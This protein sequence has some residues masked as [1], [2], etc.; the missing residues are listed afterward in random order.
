MRL[1]RTSNRHMTIPTSNRPIAVSQRRRGSAMIVVVALLGVMSFLGV[2]FF[3]FVNAERNSAGY[4]A[5]VSKEVS[6]NS[7]P[8]IY[9]N[10]ALEQVLVGPTA[11]LTHSPLYGGKHSLVPNLIG[12][13]DG[14][15]R[16]RDNYPFSGQ[17]ITIIA[18]GIDDDGFPDLD[19]TASGGGTE[20]F[21]V[22]YDGDGIADDVNG[23]GFTNELDLILNYSLHVNDMQVPLGVTINDYEPDVGY[24]Y[25]DANNMFLG[26]FAEVDYTA[27]GTYDPVPVW[28]PSFHRPQY[29][30]RDG[31]TDIYT[32]TNYKSRILRPHALHL[33]DD[34]ANRRYLSGTA[35]TPDGTVLGEFPFN[36]NN[37]ANH[38][39]DQDADGQPLEMGIWSFFNGGALSTDISLL[40]ENDYEFDLDADGD[41]VREAIIMDLQFPLSEVQVGGDFEEFVPM[42]GITI[43][44]ADALLNLNAHGGMA[45]YVHYLR[46]QLD[47]GSANLELRDVPFN[48]TFVGVSN[49]GLSSNEVNLSR[50]LYADPATFG[51][52][53]GGAIE[54]H[55]GMFDFTHIGPGT[56]IQVYDPTTGGTI[57]GNMQTIQMANM[58]FARMVLGSPEYDSGGATVGPDVTQGRWGNGT[59]LEAFFGGAGNFPHP[60]FDRNNFPAPGRINGDDDF[61]LSL[62]SAGASTGAGQPFADPDLRNLVIPPV[63][64]PV[65]VNATGR[66]FD[67]ATG[68]RLADPI[69]ATPTSVIQYV[70]N[71]TTGWHDLMGW[72]AQSVNSPVAGVIPYNFLL[73]GALQ[74][75]VIPLVHDPNSGIYSGL[76]DE[77]DE[78]IIDPSFRDVVNDAA[79]GPS[80]MEYLHMSDADATTV[81]PDS[82]AKTLMPF[83]LETHPDHDEIR[84]QFTTDSWA[85]AEF[86]FGFSQDRPWEF[87]D[88]LTL[89]P[90]GRNPN[91]RL[92]PP[93]FSGTNNVNDPVAPYNEQDPFRPAVRELLTMQYNPG[94]RDPVGLVHQRKLNINRLLTRNRQS[95]ELDYRNLTP[96]PVFVTGDAAGTVDDMIHTNDPQG[97]SFP[98]H[99]VFRFNEI[100]TDKHV[101]EWWARYDRQRL[102]RDIYVL[103]YVLGTGLDGTSAQN[104]TNALASNFYSDAQLEEMAQ[105]AVNYVDALDRDD[106]V[107]KFVFDSDLSNGWN[108]TSDSDTDA[109]V[110][111]GIETHMLN[112]SEYMWIVTDQM[113]LNN[114]SQTLYADNSQ[115]HQYLFIELRNSSAKDVD[116]ADGTWRIRRADTTTTPGTDIVLQDLTFQTGNG[117]L[118]S[119]GP[120]ETYLIG[121]HDGNIPSPS[122]QR[123]STFRIQFDWNNDNNIDSND[124][125]EAV[126]PRR[127]DPNAP[128]GD[129]SVDNE[130]PLC[131]FDLS[132]DDGTTSAENDIGNQR[133]VEHGNMNGYFLPPVDGSGVVQESQFTLILERRQ[134]LLGL[135]KLTDANNQ[136]EWVEVD[137]I[138]VLPVRFS[139]TDQT[140]ISE[141]NLYDETVTPP[142]GEL[143]NLR[144]FERDWPLDPDNPTQYPTTGKNPFFMH[145]LGEPNPNETA[146]TAYASNALPTRRN[147]SNSAAADGTDLGADQPYY[148]P[149]FNRDFTSVYELL[150]IPLYGPE[151]VR[152]EDSTSPEV[153]GM[154]NSANQLNNQDV[155]ARKFLE[156]DTNRTTAA[157]QS[158]DNRWYR[159]FAFLE[160]PSGTQSALTDRLIVPR[161]PGKININTVRHEQVV[162]AIVDDLRHL[163]SDF[164]ATDNV[165]AARNW[166]E[167][168]LLSRDRSDPVWENRNTNG[169]VSVVPL[170]GIPGSNPFR[171]TAALEAVGTNPNDMTRRT[172]D[173]TW[174][175]RLPLDD[176]DTDPTNDRRLFDAS[177]NLTKISNG[178]IDYHT[179]HR[180]LSKIANNTT[181]VSNVFIVWIEVQFHKAHEQESASDPNI[182]N[183]FIGEKLYTNPGDPENHRGF[184]IV[185]RSLLEE[186]FDPTTG[187]FDFRKFVIFRRTIQ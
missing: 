51:G 31:S 45:G 43:I 105:F 103:L 37:T 159:L 138:S 175:R 39:Q 81:S 154:V 91:R 120:G 164:N 20:L 92:F 183:V 114:P 54:Q 70:Y 24:T 132:F 152:T 150:S 15:R 26:Y 123:P 96:H 129:L 160:V 57:S 155:A 97:S 14:A 131:D 166:F 84:G 49:Q 85:R 52:G 116:L 16:M 146:N 68:S 60:I 176:V 73:S 135:D 108:I 12:C 42:F 137:R 136:N 161:R 162:S 80:E 148:Q 64:H 61:D 180:I 38:N 23:D 3:S 83:N 21:Q 4:F 122:G 174:L 184:F 13:L 90:N 47:A 72:Q 147:Q 158:T 185:D 181:D 128:N 77:D 66:S 78:V 29:L 169:D 177:E 1:K 145:T 8:D 142:T 153:D 56:Q 86:S 157:N 89:P 67:E 127:P 95:G 107:T 59:E 87:N 2:F 172:L 63:V 99:A 18:P 40:T 19:F 44:D 94:G 22:D 110:V 141:S 149:H 32:N 82:R 171:Q 143:R 36:N 79:F 179:R 126:V 167:Q 186:A 93:K 106:V 111:Y 58:E 165:E 6:A 55:E 33:A 133:F 69:T 28:I 53:F 121:S 139:P 7:G 34:G 117:T 113:S 25:P 140:N 30:P 11:D 48:N 144:S 88:N 101:Q 102:A 170:P 50:A 119:V 125:F 163:G 71:T 156:P 76:V 109:E 100:N 65:D 17:G 115:E 35:T 124:S 41:G 168:L 178:T 9:F 5:A 112:F 151:D 187:R 46:T 10:W 62:R 182:N 130:V 118:E 74:D 104:P 173:R 134:N 27:N 75:P 98:G